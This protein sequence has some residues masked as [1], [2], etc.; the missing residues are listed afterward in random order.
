MAVIS[1][2]RGLFDFLAKMGLTVR[3]DPPKV[4]Q[5]EGR[6]WGPEVDGLVLSI[7]GNRESI[8][9]V[10]RN[11]STSDR[12]LRVP[13][14]AS[15]YR[16]RVTDADGQAAPQTPFGKELV[17]PGRTAA[18]RPLQLTAG[19]AVE[20][21]IPVASIFRLSAGSAFEAQASCEVRP[22]V[23]LESN[24]VRLA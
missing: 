4:I 2:I 18:V 3:D 17:R 8:S 24:R 13:D 20:A 10:L 21:E 14:F 16:L 11:V 6:E 5:L 1:R 19:E 7:R 15:W 12:T 22:G 9:A 23:T